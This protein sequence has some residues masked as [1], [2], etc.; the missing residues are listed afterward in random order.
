MFLLCALYALL[1]PSIHDHIPQ[2]P[3]RGPQLIAPSKVL[4]PP[5][6]ATVRENC[7]H[8]LWELCWRKDPLCLVPRRCCC[9]CSCCCCCCCCCR[10]RRCCPGALFL[11]SLARRG[12]EEIP[13]DSLSLAPH[14]VK[15]ARALDAIAAPAAAASAA[16]AAAAAAA[17]H[18]P[19]VFWDSGEQEHTSL[20]N[21]AAPRRDGSYLDGRAAVEGGG[22]GGRR[23]RRRIALCRCYSS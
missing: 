10:R 8:G 1:R 2:T 5:C 12:P 13:L 21:R 17:R 23:G 16:A 9:C 20:A 22:G 3:Q 4:C 18:A 7:T 6:R 11:P 14:P 15:V 19:V